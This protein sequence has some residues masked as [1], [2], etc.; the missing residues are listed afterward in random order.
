AGQGFEELCMALEELKGSIQRKVSPKLEKLIRTHY[1]RSIRNDT[2]PFK[3][4]IFCI[5]GGCDVNDEHS[6]IAKTADDYLWL[7]LNQVN[8]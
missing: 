2:D 5:L 1:K 3:R 6:E 7:K 4:I 8:E